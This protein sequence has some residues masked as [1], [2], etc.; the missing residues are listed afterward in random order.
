MLVASSSIFVSCGNVDSNSNTQVAYQD[1]NKV[2]PLDPAG[3]HVV[4]LSGP[5]YPEES[6]ISSDGTFH[7]GDYV[8][9]MQDGAPLFATYPR[10]GA[11]V[12]K[13]LKS[14]VVLNVLGLSGKYM[15]VQSEDGDEGFIA[16]SFVVPQG[17]LSANVPLA[18]S[19]LAV[20]S[21]GE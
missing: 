9:V 15:H 11:R 6:Q 10:S 4:R 5:S 18:D 3:I 1:A 19:D 12:K 13:A 14:G 17:L 2:H 21:N 7:V 8:E 20:Q 16:T